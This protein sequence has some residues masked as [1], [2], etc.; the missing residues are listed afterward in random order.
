MMEERAVLWL[1]GLVGAS[2][3]ALPVCPMG[4]MSKQKNDAETNWDPILLPGNKN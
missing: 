4:F 2:A 3:M 1:P